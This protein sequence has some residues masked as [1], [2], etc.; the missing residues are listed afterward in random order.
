[1]LERNAN[2]TLRKLFQG[3]Y[4]TKDKEH[5]SPCSKK[6]ENATSL[7]TSDSNC[8][9]FNYIKDS[10]LCTICPQSRRTKLVFQDSYVKSTNVCIWM[11][12]AYTLIKLIMDV[13]F[14]LTIVDNFTKMT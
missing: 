4:H 2:V 8:S 9:P 5:L 10:F 11:Y 1:M 12:G 7:V 14:L 6:E 3:L 13:K